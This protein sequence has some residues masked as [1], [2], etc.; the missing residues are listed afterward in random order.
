MDDASLQVFLSL[1]DKEMAALIPQ[2][3]AAKRAVFDRM[4]EVEIDLN[5]GVVPDGVIVCNPKACRHG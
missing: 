3:T 4:A 5:M 2:L 1:S